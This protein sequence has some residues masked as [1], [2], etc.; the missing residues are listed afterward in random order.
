MPTEATGS[1]Q[2][3]L[4]R[5]GRPKGSV[6]KNKASNELVALNQLNHN[7]ISPWSF[8]PDTVK[9]KLASEHAV[10]GPDAVVKTFIIVGVSALPNGM[11]SIITNIGVQQ[12]FILVTAE[13]YT[14]VVARLFPGVK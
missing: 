2:E 7:V 11:A 4:K 5:R 9:V 13:P 1:P 3:P 10:D 12:P 6:N 14:D 8:E